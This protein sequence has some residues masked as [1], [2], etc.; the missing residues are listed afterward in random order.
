M[1]SPLHHKPLYT[2]D[3]TRLFHLYHCRKRSGHNFLPKYFLSC[4]LEST[5]EKA[6][7]EVS[8]RSRKKKSFLAREMKIDL[9]G[10]A[11]NSA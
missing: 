3:V 10:C 8:L 9:P 11:R 6:M 4:M 5:G 1:F 2:V 7:K